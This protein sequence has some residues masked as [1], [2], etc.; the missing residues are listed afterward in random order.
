MEKEMET[1]KPRKTRTGH[2]SFL[3]FFDKRI[4]YLIECNRLGTAKNYQSARAALATYLNGQKLKMKDVDRE[5]V[6]NYFDW[7]MKRGIVRNSV[8]FYL[9]IFR[10][11]YNK[12]VNKGYMKQTF[13]FEN[14]YT[15]V[16]K[17]GK[18]ALP[19]DLVLQLKSLDLSHD[20][21]L[22]M[23]R[24]FFLFSLYTRGMA[25]V[26]IVYL[27]KSNISGNIIRYER[28]KTGQP[29]T[30]SIENEAGLIMQKYL[31]TSGESPY[32]F[33]IIGKGNEDEKYHQ[34]QRAL[35]SFNYRLSILSGYLGKGVKLTSY[36][37]R[38]TW[39]TL[40]MNLNVPI[41]VISAGMGHTSERTTRIYLESLNPTKVDDANRRILDAL[42]E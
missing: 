17:T 42:N 33:P 31:R 26:D 30:V 28:R 24:D 2:L 11:V 35:S 19:A 21:S 37:P 41:S 16:D 13:P 4:G 27:K 40:A 20:K 5:F 36:T 18:R 23:T 32:I 39:A 6:D 10:A 14:V 1:T 3:E 9:R 15:G 8:S 38:H 29:I 22:V 34:Y 12:A 25:F 7:L